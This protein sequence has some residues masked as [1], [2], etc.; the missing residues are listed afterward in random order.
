M[1]KAGGSGKVPEYL[2]THPSDDRRI[3]NFKEWMPKAVSEY[4]SNCAVTRG[5]FDDF[6]ENG[7]DSRF[8]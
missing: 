2:S 4:E 5:F 7:R 1:K 3:D 8:R 6:Q